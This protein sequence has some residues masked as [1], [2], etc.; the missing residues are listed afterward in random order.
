MASSHA[1]A[2]HLPTAVDKRR[3]GKHTAAHAL[4]AFLTALTMLSRAEATIIT[5]DANSE[6]ITLPSPAT[7]DLAAARSGCPHEAAQLIP[8]HDPAAWTGGAVP[9]TAGEAA[10]LAAGVT[11]LLQDEPTGAG[12]AS[13]PLGLLTIP[14]TSELVL[15]ENVASGTLL[16]AH[17]IAVEGALRAGAESC[18]LEARV[19]IVLHGARP[20]GGEVVESWYKGIV[21]SGAGT[22]ELHG[23][24]F[25]HTWT[26]L[27][28][29]VTAGDTT[30]LLQGAVNWEP[31][32]QV[33][34]VTTALKDA[35]DWHRNEV[36]T[37]AAVPPL[38]DTEWAGS[39]VG[40]VVV[41]T[42]AAQHDHEA[43]GAYQGEVALLS[44]RIVVQ[45]ADGDSPPTD[46]APASCTHPQWRLGSN[47]VPCATTHLTGFGGHIL[48]AG[49]EATAKVAGVEL[50][51]MGQT[52]ELGRYPLH[53]H[54]MGAQGGARS[55]MRDCSVHRSY[56]RCV[57]IHGT[58]YVTISQNVA[59][60]VTGYCYYLEV[61]VKELQPQPYPKPEPQA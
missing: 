22:L 40:A 10:T 28:R 45:G 9:A 26:R 44:R 37:I 60:D 8:W 57:S 34:L 7:P 13:T 3:D 54:V 53:F 33:L 1:H 46:V 17:G 31:G 56:Y 21:V 2:L 23:K 43:I 14:S 36:L 5:A 4:L 32:Q 47:S 6:R 48:A 25:Y 16:H 29:R 49:P 35:R 11:V 59:Y 42:S 20:A 24:Q 15:G 61:R 12:S 19:S 52:N 27:A 39:G 58:S 38:Q 55:Y 41:L 50:F 30:L 51:Q 18:R